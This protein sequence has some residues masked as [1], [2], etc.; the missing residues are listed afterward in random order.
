MYKRGFTGARNSGD[1]YQQTK[2]N[3][4]V[5]LVQ[6]VRFRAPQHQL[7]ASGCA[8]PRRHRNRDLTGEIFARQRIR[9]CLDLCQFAF[10]QQLAAELAC[11]RSKIEQMIGRTQ[12]I[13]IVLHHND[14]VAQVTQFLQDMD[15]SRRVARM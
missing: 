5:E 12:H 14:G 11:A 2:R 6:V 7:F 3:V 10:G 8:P 9:V 1:R 13:G 15:Q 4:D